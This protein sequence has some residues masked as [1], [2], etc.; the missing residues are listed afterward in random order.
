MGNKYW[1]SA[2]N[3]SK[4]SWVLLFLRLSKVFPFGILQIPFFLLVID[5]YWNYNHLY[6]FI[7]AILFWNY[8]TDC[9]TRDLAMSFNAGEATRLPSIYIDLKWRI[10]TKQKRWISL[11]TSWIFW[12]HKR[13]IL[14]LFIKLTKRTCI[15]FLFYGIKLW[16]F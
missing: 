2:Y 7:A 3:L 8:F 14:K 13:H 10:E 9:F 5:D 16:H 4:I 11:I 15:W 12:T 6:W 1:D